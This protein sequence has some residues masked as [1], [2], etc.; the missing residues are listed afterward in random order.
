MAKVFL[1]IGGN[2]NNRAHCIAK[3]KKAIAGQVGEIIGQSSVY[4]SEPWGFIH[5]Q[6]FLNQVIVVETNYMPQEVLRINQLIEKQLGRHRNAELAAI[7]GQKYR[8]RCMDIDILF[9]DKQTISDENLTVPHPRLHQ[10]KF[11]LVPLY[12][13]APDFIHPLLHT[14]VRDLLA[15]CSDSGYVSCYRSQKL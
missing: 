9:Y 14:T 12:E 15:Q 5:E 1:L 8:A 13:L 2:L 6:N 3:A 10:R 11:T 4:E 7:Q